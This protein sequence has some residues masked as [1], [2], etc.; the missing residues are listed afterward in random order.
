MLRALHDF[1]SVSLHP[2]DPTALGRE[3]GDEYYIAASAR[4]RVAFAILRQVQSKGE[5]ALVFLHSKK[6]QNV[7]SV[8]I[9]R[10]LGC[11]TPKIVRG[12]VLSHRRQEI[13][14]EFS[15]QPGFGVLILSPRAAGVG[16][17]IVA[18]NHVIHL[19]RW[20]NPAV[21]DQCTYRAYRIGQTKPVWVYALAG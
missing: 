8:L 16:L 6:V 1:R 20:W 9:E 7:L 14:D 2:I 5:K 3:M 18:A 13:V 21:E 15:A 10:T 11:S 4:L 19:D 12:D 17:N